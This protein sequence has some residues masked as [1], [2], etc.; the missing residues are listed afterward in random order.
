MVLY[1]WFASPKF[2]LQKIVKQKQNKKET[3]LNTNKTKKGQIN[4]PKNC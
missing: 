1:A 2:V 3:K 4:E